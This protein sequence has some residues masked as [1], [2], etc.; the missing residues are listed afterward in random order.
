[1]EKRFNECEIKYE[2]LNG[3]IKDYKFNQ[4]EILN[5]TEKRFNE[6]EIKYEELNSIIK[7]YKS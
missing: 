7:D 5:N 2:E 3:I 1:M 6:Y 4:N